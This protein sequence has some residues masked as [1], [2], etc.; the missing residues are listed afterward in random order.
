MVM[1][2][3]PPVN[4][5]ARKGVSS[6][7]LRRVQV[8]QLPPTYEGIEAMSDSFSSPTSQLDPRAECG[9]PPGI[10]RPIG[11]E[12]RFLTTPL[13]MTSFD[14]G[15]RIRY[16][17]TEARVRSGVGHDAEEQT[18]SAERGPS[19]NEILKQTVV[20]LER[21]VLLQGQQSQPL[22]GQQF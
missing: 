20:R 5:P 18:A 15:L 6:V 3:S 12:Q 14:E 2:G 21:L 19:E 10:Q 8:Q 4:V 22:Q 7:G 9:D 1:P 13:Q 17:N 16:A 11:D